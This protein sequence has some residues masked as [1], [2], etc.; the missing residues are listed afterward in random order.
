MSHVAHGDDP[1]ADPTEWR[2]LRRDALDRWFREYIAE[3][4]TGKPTPVVISR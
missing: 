4:V 3:N 1:N 2:L